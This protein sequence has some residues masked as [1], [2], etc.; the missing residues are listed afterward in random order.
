MLVLDV[1]GCLTD[2]SIY[3]SPDGELMK[4]FNVKDGYAI[5]NILKENNIIPVVITGRKSDIVKRRCDELNV[6]DL[7][8]GSTDKLDDLY[9]LMKK[10][11]L[12]PDEVACVGDDIPE[13]GM[14]KACGISACPVDAV[15]VVRENVSYIS[16][17]AG[18]HGAVRD[19]IEW[20][21]GTEDANDEV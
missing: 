14:I 12:N 11:G 4:Q 3:M 5:K 16:H 13:L 7:I 8:Q 17:F 20:L 2:G 9:K 6:I 10:Y 18:G 1:D 15:K 21:L 19:I